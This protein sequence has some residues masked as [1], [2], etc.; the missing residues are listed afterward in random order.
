MSNV[1]DPSASGPVHLRPVGRGDLPG[2]YVMQLDPES[3]RMAVTI[4]WTRE[5]FDS[6]WAAMLADPGVTA[7]AVLLGEVPI[8]YACRF[9]RGGHDH[10]GYWI[11]REHWGRGVASRALELLLREVPARPLYAH[12]ATT[13]GASLRVLRKCGFAFERV[14]MSPATDR[15]PE[16]EEAVL[17][18]R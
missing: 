16:C 15:Y 5:A 4:P 12:V 11:D 1:T 9:P 8:G 17:V 18:L 2:V 13:N 7:R 14:Q 6:H 3:N 10:V